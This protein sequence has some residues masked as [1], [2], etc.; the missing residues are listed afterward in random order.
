MV[1]IDAPAT[2]NMQLARMSR[3][4]IYQIEVASTVNTALITGSLLTG[5]KGYWPMDEASGTRADAIGGNHLT[6][7]NSVTSATGKVNKA[8][9]FIAENLEYL[10]VTPNAN[11]Q[12]SGNFSIAGWFY[13]F[14]LPTM[15]FACQD[16]ATA[17][18]RCWLLSYVAGGTTRFQFT[19]YDNAGAQ[20]TVTANNFGAPL[21]GQWYFIACTRDGSNIKISVN[22]GT[23]DSTAS[24]RTPTTTS[25]EVVFGAQPDGL[26]GYQN[27]TNCRIDE[28]GFWNKALSTSE[29]TS[30][31]N[32]GVGSSLSNS[33]PIYQFC[34]SP[35]INRENIGHKILKPLSLTRQAEIE[36][37][38]F[39][40]STFIFILQDIGK[41]ATAVV[42]AGLQGLPCVL[43]AGFYEIQ[44]SE[45]T[46]IFTGI[47]TEVEYIGGAY[48]VTARSPL[49]NGLDKIIFKG[50]QTRLSAAMTSSDTTATV[51][52]AGQFDDAANL[53]QSKRRNFLVDNEIIVY[54]GKTG[55]SFTSCIRVTTFPFFVP[56]GFPDTVSVAH[57][58]GAPVR[59]MVGMMALTADNDEVA[60]TINDQHPID[61]LTT[62]LTDTDTKR[63]IGLSGG[64]VNT[65]ELASVRTALGSTL[66]F[67][68]LESDGS[69]GKDFLEKEIYLP[70]AAYPTEDE[71][72]RIGIKLY[73]SGI[74]PS[75]AGTV[76]DG[77]IVD[78]PR[79]LRNAEKQINTVIYHYD[80]NPLTNEYTSTYK[81][82]D[83]TLLAQHGRE[84]QLEIFSKGIRSFFQFGS[85][86][87]FTATASFLTAAAQRHIARFG[88][89]APVVRARTIFSKQLLEVA[90]DIRATFNNVTDLNTADRQIINAAMEISRMDIDFTHNVIEMELLGYPS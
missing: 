15:V 41:I 77:D 74:S 8:A 25:Q 67:R 28:F 84:L 14:N 88:N 89:K 18:A 36:R 49:V 62:I 35:S 7:H 78:D 4:P 20:D 30:L 63:G 27:W 34:T 12:V 5:L 59:E 44:W 32:N 33:I 46:I 85:Q 39:A 53:P 16:G 24:T 37:G 21:A 64:F 13:L 68:F 1:L 57:N 11:L 66:R 76:E 61:Y 48:K 51:V 19:V 73:G 80:H 38:R 70:L 65:E 6:D 75:I 29:I 23:Q 40:L 55:T 31:Y 79:W 26:G 72:G 71:R 3:T 69:N 45:S 86:Q 58:S 81:Y 82:Q 56:P 90:D 22:G 17:P 43:R 47:I 87:W 42:S 10:T 83:T 54:R 60:G 2:Y 9:Q 50:A 52:D